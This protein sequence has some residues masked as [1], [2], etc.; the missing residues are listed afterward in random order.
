MTEAEPVRDAG[1]RGRSKEL[2]AEVDAM[3]KEGG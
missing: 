3:G 2:Q 1:L